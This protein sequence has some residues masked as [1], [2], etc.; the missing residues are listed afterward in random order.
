MVR[1]DSRGCREVMMM[2]VVVLK[3]QGLIM[4]GMKMGVVVVVKKVLKTCRGYCW[5]GD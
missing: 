3:V 5:E 1:V 4:V 2:V